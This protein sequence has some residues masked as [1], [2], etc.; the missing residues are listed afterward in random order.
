MIY[1]IFYNKCIEVLT[2]RIPFL[3]NKRGQALIEFVLLMMVVFGLVA[4]IYSV[5][6]NHITTLWETFLNLIVDDSTQKI[7]LK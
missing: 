2:N 5:S 4:L 3:I 7:R 6:N 1:R